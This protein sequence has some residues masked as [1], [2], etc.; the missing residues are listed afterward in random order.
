[1]TIDVG[2]ILYGELCL[3]AVTIHKA[4]GRMTGG[5]LG[6]VGDMKNHDS[7]SQKTTVHF[8]LPAADGQVG[9]AGGVLAARES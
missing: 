1:M 5:L 9:S 6:L 3:C 2:L 7:N 4:D 8:L